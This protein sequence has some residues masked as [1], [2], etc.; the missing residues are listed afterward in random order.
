MTETYINLTRP[1]AEAAFWA[2]VAAVIELLA[3]SII[4]F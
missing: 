1:M 2:T 3:V 4:F